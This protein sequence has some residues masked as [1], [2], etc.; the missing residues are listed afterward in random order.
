LY[1]ENEIFYLFILNYVLLLQGLILSNAL[2]A[3]KNIEDEGYTIALNN[4]RS[5]VIELRNEG[6]EKDKIL[7]SLVNKVKEDEASFKAQVEIQKNEIEDLRKQLAE[8]K[9]KCCLA[10]AN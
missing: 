7:I 3:L 6:L 1:F 2:R 4:L 10:E 9:E 8:A 5:E